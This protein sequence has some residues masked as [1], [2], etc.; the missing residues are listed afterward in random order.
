MSSE[1]ARLDLR[2]NIIIFQRASATSLYANRKT[3]KIG[4]QE[5]EGAGG[6]RE[7]KV[8]LASL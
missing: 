4:A 3:R 1:A 8:N 5:L 2:E 6:V 7:E